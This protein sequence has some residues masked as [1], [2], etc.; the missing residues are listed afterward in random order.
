MTMD[1]LPTDDQ[2]A[3]KRM[4]DDLLN[5]VT[6]TVRLPTNEL[7]IPPNPDRLPAKDGLHYV[8]IN[9]LSTKQRERGSKLLDFLACRC[10]R[11]SIEINA[12]YPKEVD[13]T[14]TNTKNCLARAVSE[15]RKTL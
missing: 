3:L 11:K 5:G 14:D 9:D 8:P 13:A 12:G 6:G 2:E 4:V 15:S 7:E 10:L 1:K